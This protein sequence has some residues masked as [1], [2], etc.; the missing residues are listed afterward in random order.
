VTAQPR[1]FGEP[2]AED[3]AAAF[4]WPGARTL[5]S[6]RFRT[7]LALALTVVGA[8]ILGYLLVRQAND[9]KGQWAFDFTTYYGAAA[10]MAAGQS[11]YAASMFEGPIPAQG[12]GA[13]LYKYPPPL[14]QLLIPISHVPLGLAS[15]Y[16]FVVQLV[17]VLGG[18]WLAVRAGGA[19]STVETFAWCAV[20]TTFFLPVFATLWMGN[21]SGFMAFAVAVG[22]LGG[23]AAGGAAF[24]ATLLKFTP[25]VLI[26]PVL[27]AGRRALIGLLALL[28]VL[29]L[30]FVLAPSAW[31]DF[32]RVIP[33]LLSGPTLFENNLALHSLVTYGLP[34]LPWAP[35]AARAL[36]VGVGLAALAGSVVLARRSAG[37][38]AALTLSVAALLLLPSALWY[39]YLCVLLPLAAFAW[40]HAA[41]RTRLGLL[42]GAG[43][44]TFG[45]AALPMTVVGAA[46]MT[47]STLVAVWPRKAPAA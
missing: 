27:F 31:F 11:P 2:G 25:V 33:N 15:V 29:A 26:A 24:A 40:T 1:S 4:R 44:I 6:S 10:D 41:L 38:P 21:V 14:A 9:P 23:V 20:A 32:L 17:A 19:R 36:S 46:L 34:Q 47:G 7:V 30:S 16:Y 13:Q 22:L 35:E 45:L 5:R 12:T 37:W 18:V 28:P 42:A 8:V 39:H 3:A 43:M